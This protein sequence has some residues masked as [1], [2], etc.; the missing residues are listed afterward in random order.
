MQILS[1]FNETI[2]SLNTLLFTLQTNIDPIIMIESESEEINSLIS[3]PNLVDLISKSQANIIELTEALKPISKALKKQSFNNKPKSMQEYADFSIDIPPIVKENYYKVPFFEEIL[4]NSPKEIKPINRRN[5]IDYQDPCPHCSAPNK[6]VYKHSKT[7]FRCKVC[8]LTF[9]Y[10]IT[11][12]D[13]ITHHCPYCERKLE[14][15][16]E[17]VNYDVLI[18]PNYKCSFYL[19]NKKQLDKGEARHLETS[20][21]SHKLRYYFRLFDFSMAQIKDLSK[22][23]IN[24]KIDLSKIE[25]SY[26][27]VGLVLTYY[28]NYGLSSRRTSQILKEVHSIKISHQTVVN[29]AEAAASILEYL[30]DNYNYNLNNTITFDETYIKVS[31]KNNY[32]FFGSDTNNKIITS[33]RIFNTRTTKEAVITLNE[34]FKKFRVLPNDLTVITDGNPIYNAAQVFYNMNDINFDLYQVI[35]VKNND[36]ISRKYRHYKQAEE[37]LNRTYKQNYYGTNGYG[38]LRNAN[39]YMSLY[40]TFFNFLRRHSSLRYK[41][42]III[43][44][45]DQDDLMPNK[46]LFLI[47]YTLGMI[48][49]TNVEN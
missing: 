14:F 15:K 9:T 12:H 28:I 25:K 8:M 39:V 41:S 37:R 49:N 1:H 32:V 40:V 33:Y 17:R 19:N 31:G 44:E 42:P 47:D 2:K 13:D 43:D 7:Q 24:S 16:K 38:S 34:S 10:K 21:K 18:C 45:M 36:D 46:W 29:Y 27:V 48:N 6:Y 35:G 30:N 5:E 11:K 22:L 3:S 26:Y 4:E 23:S 20:S